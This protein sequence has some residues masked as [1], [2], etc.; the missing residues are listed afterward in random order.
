[1]GVDTGYVVRFIS[2]KLARNR[3]IA[4]RM[5]TKFIQLRG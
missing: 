4:F 2:E 1:M 3:A 5:V